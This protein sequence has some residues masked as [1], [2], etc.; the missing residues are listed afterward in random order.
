MDKQPL[1]SSPKIAAWKQMLTDAGCTVRRL[2]PIHLLHKKNGDLLFALLDADVVSKEGTRLPNIVFIRGDACL[3]VP[4]VRNHDTGEERFLMIRQRR[5][6]SGLL[7]LEFPAGMLDDETGN[8]LG[9]AVR[10]LEEETGLSVAPKELF[11][12]CDRKLFS[13]V[14][15]SDEGIYYYGCVK[16]LDGDTF[17]ALS[18]TTRGSPDEGERISVTLMTKEDAVKEATSLQVRLG[19]HLFDRRTT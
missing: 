9:V 16:E 4:L 15:A 8:P 19:L 17:R 11:P 3:I 13:S 10:E 7:S 6:G 18:G 2:S 5:I 12:L 14:G 1:E